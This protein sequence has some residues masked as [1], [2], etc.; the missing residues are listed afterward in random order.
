[1]LRKK[2]AAMFGGETSHLKAKQSKNSDMPLTQNF[3]EIIKRKEELAK[4]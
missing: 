1:M 4:S 3:D 2:M